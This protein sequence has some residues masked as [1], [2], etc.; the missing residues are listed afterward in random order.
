MITDA[1]IMVLEGFH[2]RIPRQIAGITEWRGDGSEW[3]WSLL[4]AAL[5]VTGLWMIREYV[6]RWQ[7]T[8]SDYITGRPI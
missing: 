2:H 5:E 1:I 8:I 3:K 6:R 4:N 7:A